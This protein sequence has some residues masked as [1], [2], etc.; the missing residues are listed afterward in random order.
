MGLAIGL[1][2]LFELLGN[3][4]ENLFLVIAPLCIVIYIVL[5]LTGSAGLLVDVVKVLGA[6]VG[7]TGGY[8][9]EKKYVGYNVK[10]GKFYKHLIKIVMGLVGIL[11]IKEG[12]K[13]ILPDVAFLTGF[14]RYLLVSLFASFV[15][16]LIFKKLKL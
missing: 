10:S 12:L 1:T 4:E 5:E 2:A 6:Y 11:I 15:A 14:L 7:F 3:K 16:P 13:I 8:Y 9:L